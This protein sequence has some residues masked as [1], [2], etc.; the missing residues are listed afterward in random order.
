MSDPN[1]KTR[2]FKSVRRLDA[3]ALQGFLQTPRLAQ[4]RHFRGVRM[5]LLNGRRQVCT[6]SGSCRNEFRL[7]LISERSCDADERGQFDIL[8][9]T[10]DSGNL[11]SHP[12][13][14]GQ[15]GLRQMTLLSHS[16]DRG[17]LSRA[18]N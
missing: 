6:P 4:E 10:F 9:A 12:R 5:G 8:G 16:C 15:L 17:I 18:L 13:A 1:P 11:R 3:P 14:R 7:K 2:Q